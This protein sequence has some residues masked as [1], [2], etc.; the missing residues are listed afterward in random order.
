MG[1]LARS[2]VAME[3]KGYIMTEF[4]LDLHYQREIYEFDSLAK[5]ADGSAVL[6]LGNAVLLATVSVAKDDPVEEDFLPLTVNYIEKAYAAGKVPGGFF[7]REA[8]PSEF[9]TLCSRIIDRTI[10]PLFPKGFVYPVVVTV[11]VLSADEKS[12][13]QR[14]ALLA[15]NA[16]L[17]NS[18][19]PIYKNVAGLRVVRIDGELRVNPELPDLHRSDLDLF[20]AGSKDELLMIEMQ[21]KKAPVS[22]SPAD[23]ALDPAIGV[24]PN[25]G[26]E[27]TVAMS[28]AQLSEAIDMAKRALQVSCQA[29]ED[30]FGYMGA[31]K[32]EYELFVPEVSQEIL[33]YIASNKTQDIKDAL[34][35]MAR[36]ERGGFLKKIAKTVAQERQDFDEEQ[37]SLAIEILK[38]QTV[39]NMI[40]EN[41]RADGRTSTQIRDISIRT[42]LLPKAHGSALFTRGQT[43]ALVVTTLGG[44]SDRQSVEMLTSK[45]TLHD[46]FALH[47]NFHPF[48]VNEARPPRPP[49][50]R[51]LGHGNLA[52]RALDASL[53]RNLESSIRL[54]SEILESNGSSSMASVCGGALALRAA[55][56]NTTDLVAGVA[57]GLVTQDDKEMILSDITGL[58]DHDGDMD[59]K[60]AGTKDGVTA[61]QMDI[62]LGGISKE[63]LDRALLQAKDA[64]VHI[65]GIMQEAAN[66][67]VINEGALPK[68]EF[69]TVSTDKI[70]DIIGQAGKTIRELIETFEVS[71]DLDRENGGV[72]VRGDDS[73]L[74]DAAVSKIKE[75]VNSKPTGRGGM[76]GGQKR[77]NAVCTYESG[78]VFTGTIEKILEFGMLVK[79]PDG[80]VGM[81][82]ISK[83][84]TARISKI[85][86]YF[87]EGESVEVVFSKQDKRTKKIEL[88]LK[89]K[90]T[91]K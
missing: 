73:G 3:I 67:I 35:K 19:L 11:M 53:P 34:N 86:D 21:T 76:R 90:V 24:A 52:R 5:Q 50:R 6:R 13:L 32:K 2:C 79:L 65:L 66:N 31:N 30:T 54:V 48:C 22:I 17:Y 20:V 41:N 88:D 44:D 51:E 27:K 60:V 63:L 16:A 61:L 15:A 9:E 81:V 29:Y 82:H 33:D 40:M 43:Q 23:L 42:N 59:F 45:Q 85:I 28:E 69:F 10:R 89:N 87:K 58:E 26:D 64:R 38:K 46:D 80:N 68:T 56:I 14:A 47:Y 55:G 83:I 1:S 12:D 62:K 72:K 84:S 49:G 8:K 18:P 39:R 71:I 57:M 37:I 25:I 91:P 74:V 78:E 75:I 77:E 4:T 70:V 36:T 7:K